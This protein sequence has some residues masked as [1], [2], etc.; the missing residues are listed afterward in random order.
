M[1]DQRM[2]SA[3]IS[4]LSVDLAADELSMSDIDYPTEEPPAADPDG[5]MPL[6]QMVLIGIV[7]ALIIVTSIFGNILVCVAVATEDKLRRTGNLF[8]VSLAMADLLVSFFVM[9]F[10]MFNDLLGYWVFSHRFCNVWVSFDIMFSTASILNLCAISVD[11][12]IHI[13]RPFKYYHW[14]TKRTVIA[15]IL[16]VWGMSAL[17]SFIPIHLGWHK[18]ASDTSP[19]LHPSSHLFLSPSNLSNLTHSDMQT[20]SP[21]SITV[22]HLRPP[23]TDPGDDYF[24]CAMSLNATY[25]V[26]SSLISF[27]IPCLIMISIY[28]CIFKAVRERMRNARLG[29]LGSSKNHHPD[30]QYH[31]NS[32]AATDHKAAITLGIIMGVFLMCWLPFFIYNIV[33]PLCTSCLFSELA[34][35]ILTWLGYFNSC[36]NPV[37]YS[38]FNRDFRN[39]FKNILFYQLTGF[40]CR[41]WGKRPQKRHRGHR[42]S[43]TKRTR[44]S[45]INGRVR[46]DAPAYGLRAHRKTNISDTSLETIREKISPT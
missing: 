37:I 22:S 25:A 41:C 28:A 16:L 9:P 40:L 31:C 32:Q 13:K 38:I 21:N 17:I 27:I 5:G 35:K 42:S 29:R 8:I 2:T 36:L 39:A 15:M 23:D 20:L 14:M 18:D 45:D 34:F 1:Q 46:F 44:P 10:A 11:R 7:L 6:A 26:F 12:Y 19:S 30:T 4:T 43:I 3:V 24:E 33:L